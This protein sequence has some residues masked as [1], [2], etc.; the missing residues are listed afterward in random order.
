MNTNNSSHHH[1]TYSFQDNGYECE[2][3][4][5]EKGRVINPDDI[6]YYPPVNLKVTLLEEDGLVKLVPRPAHRRSYD[7]LSDAGSEGSCSSITVCNPML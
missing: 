2:E 3:C 1:L 4:R 6:M 5:V 7:S